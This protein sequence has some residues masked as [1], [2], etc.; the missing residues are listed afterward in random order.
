[1]NFDNNYY[2]LEDGG[3]PTRVIARMIDKALLEQIFGRAWKKHVYNAS[4][5][6]AATYVLGAPIMA[7][8]DLGVDP[9]TLKDVRA[10]GRT[11]LPK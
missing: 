1:V 9:T 2:W 6:T 4:P 11:Q 10:I 8:S 5:S 3:G 7:A